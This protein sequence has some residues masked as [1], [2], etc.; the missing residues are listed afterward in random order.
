MSNFLLFFEKY[1]AYIFVHLIGITLRYKLQTPAKNERVLYAFW[2]RNI[3]PLLYLHRDQNV[4]IMISSSKDGDII[5]GPTSLFGYNVVRGSSSRGGSKATREMIKL[6]KKWTLAITPDGPR[7]PAKKIKEGLLYLA[8]FTK[9][10]I[11]PIDVEVKREFIFNSW[12]KFRLP[13]L[14]SKVKIFYGHKIFINS[15]EEIDAK[16]EAVE[17]EF[18]RIEKIN[19]AR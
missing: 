17:M 18:Q 2:H 9:L 14:F 13:K 11:V 8:Y 3:I 19:K 1:F 16:K 10:P 7:G 5:A 12:D 4:V 6:A 15:K